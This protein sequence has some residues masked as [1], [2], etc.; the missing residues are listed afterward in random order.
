[1]NEFGGLTFR[2]PTDDDL[3]HAAAVFAAEEQEVR[4]KV[5][6]GVDEMCD[7]WPMFDLAQ[8]SWI[9][10]DAT[11]RPVAFSGLMQRGEDFDCWTSVDP[12]FAGRGLAA[13]LLRRA[14]QTVRD[15]GGET[16]KAGMLAGNERAR[17][18]FEALGFREVRHFYRMQ[19]DFDGA[20]PEPRTIDGIR[21]APFERGDAPAFHA[22]LNEGF[23]DEWG[24]VPMPYDEWERLRVDAPR[25]D[26]SLWFVAWDADE[27]AGV[28]RCDAEKFGGGFVGALAVRKPWR[29]RGIGRAL[30]QQA[31][32]EFHRRGAPRVSLGVDAENPT[33]ATRLYE[34]A[35][36]RVVSEDVLFAKEVA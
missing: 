5:T 32:C 31:F 13:E 33:G 19:I 36:M 12:R 26:T 9:V 18:L 14:Q 24:F 27:V 6:L 29:G 21:L 17:A 22:A 16:L 35:G 25:A 3:P 20:P 30:L 15:R 28:I 4:G 11:G 34:R 2:R 23:A 10:A 8:G 7:W 1:V